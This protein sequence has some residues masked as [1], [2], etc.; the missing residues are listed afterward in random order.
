[1]NMNKLPDWSNLS[2]GYVKTNSLVSCLYSN[3]KWGTLQSSSDDNI[4]I[5]A[6]SA[7]LHYGL[8]VFEGLKAYRGVDGVIR[9][10]RPDEN[11]KRLQRSAAYL[12]M[13]AP[14]TDLFMKAVD[15]AVRE[16]LEFIPPYESGATLYIRPLLLGVGPQMGVKPSKDYLFL[17]A[18]SPVGNYNGGTGAIKVLIDRDHDR[19]AP[20]GTGCFKVGGN[21]AAAMMSGAMAKKKGYASVLY[22]D[23]KEKKWIDECGTSN[24]FAIKD[25]KYITPYS[26]SILPSITNKSIM[27]IATS[28]GMEVQQ[29][30]IDVTEL[31]SFDE[32]GSCGTAVVICPICQIDDPTEKHS[33]HYPDA[34]GPGTV[35][36][37]LYD[38]LYNIQFGLISDSF[39]WTKAL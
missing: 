15:M 9:L 37:R 24:F 17:V 6:L 39:G 4:T 27:E 32:V 10:F 7:A 33:Y 36:K 18:V 30:A 3:G 35:S 1:M 21:Y 29:R 23:P 22:L 16:N 12:G 14:D 20:L 28:F 31:E 25:N 13:T 5:S 8:Q 34:G 26:S 2:F 11:A 38:A 19:A